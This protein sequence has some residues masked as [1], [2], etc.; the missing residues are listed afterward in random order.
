MAVDTSSQYTVNIDA[1]ITA[2]GCLMKLY[3]AMLSMPTTYLTGVR[4]VKVI[5][6][7]VLCGLMGFAV[8]AFAAEVD[9]AAIIKLKSECAALPRPNIPDYATADYGS[10]VYKAATYYIFLE[11][12][13]N[14]AEPRDYD[15][16]LVDIMKKL[17]SRNIL[18]M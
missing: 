10:T 11:T 8:N 9:K 12:D 14:V 6:Q 5:R 7:L 18:T 13:F 16:E 4:T 1:K 17:M 15:P 2:N 3:T